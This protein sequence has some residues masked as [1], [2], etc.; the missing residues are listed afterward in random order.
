[1][2]ELEVL[3]AAASFAAI[4]GAQKRLA[5]DWLAELASAR[6]D[7]LPQFRL[8]RKRPK[9]SHFASQ[10]GGRTSDRWAALFNQ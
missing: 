8:G 1:M 7:G 9:L 10:T 6:R 2:V 5:A 4:L 3:V